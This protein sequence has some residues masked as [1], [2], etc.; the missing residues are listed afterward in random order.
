MLGAWKRL[1][2]LLETIKFSHSA[3]ALP[4]ALLGMFLAAG[5]WPDP[6]KLVGVAVCMVCVRNVAMSYNRLSDR[7]L[8]RSNP[9]TAGRALAT[10]RLSRGFVWAF[11]VGSGSVAAVMCFLFYYVFG[12]VTPLAL[13]LPLLFYVCLYS[14]AKRFTWLSHVWLGSVLG[15]SVIAAFVVTEP[16]L[17]GVGAF[18]LALG[19]CLWVA[20]F[21][22]VYAVLDVDFDREK[23]LFSIP[24]R[25]GVHRGLWVARVLHVG[26]FVGFVLGG[27]WFDLGWFYG[28]GLV[29]AGGLMVFQHW[30]VRSGGRLKGQTVFF[31]SNGVLSIFLS[32]MG[33]LDVLV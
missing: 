7:R 5:G 19:V 32:G 14:H 11:L 15:L 21:D 26:A 10:G 27:Y 31:T 12:N 25:F 30:L 13:L 4:F 16:S 29:V 24:A 8:D 17:P 9:R 28:A 1:L 3:F 22:I 23:G 2:L 6:Y 33:I 18:V 20:G